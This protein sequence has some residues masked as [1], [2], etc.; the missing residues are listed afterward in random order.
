M[1]KHFIV[2]LLVTVAILCT[3]CSRKTDKQSDVIKIGAILPLTG[4]ISYFGEYEKNAF[5]LYKKQNSSNKI[6]IIYGDSKNDPKTSLNV[7]NKMVN[8]DDTRFI[9][10][11]MTSVSQALAPLLDKNKV[12]LFSLAM[13]PTFAS[14][15]KYAVRVYEDVAD[16]SKTVFKYIKETYGKGKITIAYLTDPW[17]D[18]AKNSFQKVIKSNGNFETDYINF[19]F[20]THPNDII[21]KIIK[22]KPD[23]IYIIGYGPIIINILKK[24]EENNNKAVV[25]GNIGMSWE[26]IIKGA[27][28]AI[29]DC[30][31]AMPKFL[32]EEDNS[33]FT[34]A[35]KTMYG[36]VP[37]FEAAYSYDLINLIVKFIESGNE[38]FNIKK[39]SGITG[40]MSFDN[41][42][43]A[44]MSQ[45][46]IRKVKN[47]KLET[48][49][50]Y[51]NK[52]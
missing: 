45:C 30:Y 47:G 48:I 16:E 32:P 14:K 5:D 13:D 4:K 25:F 17:G 36:K 28:S 39:Y 42:G 27:G 21:A 22:N 50:I 15:S 41:N 7:F 19:N 52:K 38:N 35:Y 24:L 33:G 20:K 8:L 26:Y 31:I 3:N 2:I 44:K 29:E 37:N 18:Y 11:Q 1:K 9:M 6:E 23:F 40:N 43:N 46:A 10:T 12:F 49:K 34:Q 51:E